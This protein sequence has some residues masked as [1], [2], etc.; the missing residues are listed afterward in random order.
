VRAKLKRIACIQEVPAMD[1][2]EGL[3][4]KEAA[5]LCFLETE[6]TAGAA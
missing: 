5:G 1:C 2:W 3:F 4:A 6:A